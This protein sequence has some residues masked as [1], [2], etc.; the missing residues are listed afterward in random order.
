MTPENRRRAVA[1][2]RYWDAL[3]LSGRPP[4]AAGLD[5]DTADHIDRLWELSAP[6]SAEEARQR[7]WRRVQAHAIDLQ[8]R[9]DISTMALDAPAPPPRSPNGRYSPFPSPGHEAAWWRRAPG[10]LA[11]AALLLLVLAASLLATG[12]VRDTGESLKRIGNEPLAKFLWLATGGP[13]VSFG[14]PLQPAIDA[15]GN[16]WVP[17]VARTHSRILLFAP[18]GTFLEDWGALGSGEGEFT[19]KCTGLG[20]G[21]IAFDAAGNIYVAD[22]GNQRVQK[23]GP[24]R[25]FLTSWG[26]SGTADDQF[27][28]PAAVAVDGQGRVYVADQGWG[29]IKVFTS[30]GVWLATWSGLVAP[31]GI[32]IAGDG[33][34][35]VADADGGI[36]H[37]SAEGERIA[38][39]DA[40]IFGDEALNDPTGIAVDAQGRVYVA[41]AGANKIH[42][43][44]PEGTLLGSWGERGQEAGQFEEPHGIVLDGQGAAY[45]ADFF[46]QRV[47]KFRL[48]PPL[49]P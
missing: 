2:D 6:P 45:V 41:D 38:D 21:G 1:V 34:I 24:D 4:E 40:S 47:Q 9:D 39:W 19:F 20:L 17:D 25:A 31:M 3:A 44:A 37:F 35:W 14:E 26:S 42:V 5:R 8:P 32:A 22:A 7:V 46:G 30:D 13:S 23:F 33:S 18:D 11:T 10:L 15:D 16:L 29:K 48:Q 12:M 36:A 49:A 43:F 28:C 27:L